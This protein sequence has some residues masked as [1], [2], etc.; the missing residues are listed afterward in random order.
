MLIY[1]FFR[2]ALKLPKPLK[3]NK[4]SGL[5]NKSNYFQKKVPEKES[6]EN[7]PEVQSS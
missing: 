3:K 5:L 4:V 7:V 1:L 2:V 6:P